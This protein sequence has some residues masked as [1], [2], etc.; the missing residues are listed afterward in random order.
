MAATNS[1]RRRRARS[2]KSTRDYSLTP[3]AKE[4][5]ST[6]VVGYVMDSLRD[7][8]VGVYGLGFRECSPHRVASV[9]DNVEL[10]FVSFG[11]ELPRGISGDRCS[12]ERQIRARREEPTAGSPR[13]LFLKMSGSEYSYF[14]RGVLRA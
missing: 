1:C 12:W 13:V 10:E 5:V 3:G 7:L 4:W 2:W 6:A 8:G 14:G 9:L 11:D